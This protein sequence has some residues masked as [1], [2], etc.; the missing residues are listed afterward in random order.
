[1]KKKR[2]KAD[3]SSPGRQIDPRFASVV[4]AFAG[5][6]SVTAGVMMSSFGLKVNGKIFAMTTRG[7]FV[8]KLP[9]AR[10]DAIVASGLG[11]NFDPGHGRLMKEWVAIESNSEDWIALAR[12]ARDFVERGKG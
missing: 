3:A 11:E 2:S 10:V 8:T 1:M 9:K 5:D 6:P 12:E 4:E 7:K